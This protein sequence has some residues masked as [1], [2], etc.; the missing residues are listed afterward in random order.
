MTLETIENIWFRVT[1]YPINQGFFLSHPR[2]SLYLHCTM[3]IK[4]TEKP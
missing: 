3:T 1:K 4:K 2:L